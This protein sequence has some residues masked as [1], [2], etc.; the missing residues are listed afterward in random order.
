M[1]VCKNRGCVRNSY[2]CKDQLLINKMII[3]DC[4]KNEKNSCMTWIDHGKACDRV[5]D[6]WILKTLQMYRLNERLFKF[7]EI[8][9]NKWNITLKLMAMI[10]VSQQIRSG[11]EE[12]SFN[13]THSHLY[14]SSL[15]YPCA[16]KPLTSELTTSGYGYNISKT[17]IPIS[18][19]FYMP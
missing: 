3:D 18:N 11:S 6:S 7:M 5:P 12:R 2:G 15:P 16:F 14:Y 1:Y 10:D 19:L 4:K 17:S 13:E 8:S 9:M